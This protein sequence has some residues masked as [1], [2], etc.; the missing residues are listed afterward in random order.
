VSTTV[1][2]NLPASV[3]QRL[4]TLSRNRQEP[5]NTTLVRYAIER[6]LYRLSMSTYADRFLLKGAMLIVILVGDYSSANSG[7]RFAELLRGPQVV[8][9]SKTPDLVLQ[10]ILLS[11]LLAHFCARSLMHEAAHSARNGPD[12]LFFTHPIS[13]SFYTSRPTDLPPASV[14]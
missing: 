4:L 13:G 6:L 3:R 7:C 8:L 11:L 12:G 5:F 1:K 9:R 14:D 10:R 2:R